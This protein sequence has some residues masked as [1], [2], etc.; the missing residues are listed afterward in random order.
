[1]VL[2]EEALGYL[3][4]GF[5]VIPLISRDKRPEI[6]W[7][8][9][10][11]RK[12]TEDEVRRW[13]SDEK[14]NV[15]IICGKVSG[16][17]VVF[18][19]DNQE[20]MQF[21]ISDIKSVSEKTLVV[22]TGKGFHL[23]YRIKDP[24]Y[25]RLSNLAVDVKGEGGYVVAPPSI[26]PSGV[27]YSV[28]G[29]RKVAEITNEMVSF[30]KEMDEMYPIAKAVLPVW[31]REGEHRHELSLG[32]ASFFRAR[33]KWP[34]EKTERFI[35][36]VMRLK[37]DTEEQQDRMRAIED[38]YKKEYPYNRHLQ[39]ELIEQLVNLLP[40]GSGEIWRWYDKG[41]KDAK[42]WR[43]YMCD[44]TGVYRLYHNER[45]DKDGNPI[46]QEDSETI[47]TQPLTLADAWHA[48]GDEENHVRFTFFLGKIK[49]QGTKTEIFQQ[50][51]ASGL[52]GINWNFIRDTISAC[53]EFYVSTGSVS[54]RQSYEAI[55]IYETEG[56][57]ELALGDKDISALRG[58][59]PWYVLRSFE[60]YA[61]NIQDDLKVFS[62]LPD[63]FDPHLLTLFFGFSAIAPFSYALKGDGD[64]FWP[65]LI[66]KGPKGT[67]KTVLGE[68]FTTYLYG[69]AEGGPADVTSDFRL[70]DFITG[71]T[72]PRLVDE[73]ENAKFEGQKFSIKISTTLKD[74]S[75][76]QLVGTRGNIDR[77]KKLYSARTPLILAGNKIDIEDPALLARTIILNTD[78][79]DK[80]KG[81]QRMQFGA[82]VLRKLHKGFGTRLVNFVLLD[83]PTRQSITEEI[84]KISIPF[85][86]GDPRR[87]DFYSSIYFGLKLWNAFYSSMDLEFP[88][89]YYLD[90]D[91]FTDIIQKIEES[92]VEES[93]ERQSIGEF[94]EWMKKE[95]DVLEEYIKISAEETREPPQRYYELR[96]MIKR[97]VVNN[98]T[99]LYITQAAVTEYCRVN[100]TFQSRSLSEI[101]DV[102]AEYYGM[103]RNTFYDKTARWFEGRTAKAI[104]V[105]LSQA[106]LEDYGK[107]EKE[108]GKPPGSGPPPPA[109]KDLTGL[110]KPNHALV[111]RENENSIGVWSTPNQLT[112]KSDTSH[113]GYNGQNAPWGNNENS[114]Y[115]VRNI[116]NNKDSTKN[117]DLTKDLTRP[118][119]WLGNDD[120][121]LNSINEVKD[122]LLQYELHGRI[123]RDEGMV[124][125]EIAPY[126]EVAHWVSDKIQFMGFYPI[127]S[128]DTTKLTFK[129]KEVPPQ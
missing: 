1:M 33:A 62:L 97:D 36:G 26:H 11:K 10:Q 59:E 69:I 52:T 74:A 49:Y 70:L 43:A 35:E 120:K 114:G 34:K 91:R 77:T 127:E 75:Q 118:N 73:S 104:K 94:I 109:S 78:Q 30:L 54:V 16:D 14:K 112:E 29:S 98:S 51:V 89:A 124:I 85:N 46:I 128:S 83:H 6:N 90:M 111:R 100:T 17:L 55:G 103:D 96:Q 22:R 19:F 105:P 64:F 107:T 115:V 42:S 28:M 129:Y 110:T 119:H 21:V 24:P 27:Q 40:V 9:Y 3:K 50:I 25:F 41:D 8:E 18:D 56:K 63:Y 80:V 31:G 116:V 113:E 60:K 95:A 61:G 5:S 102:L 68:L 81:P 13:F 65:L 92:N 125:I 126:S 122:F 101:A 71:T 37:G 66:F 88:L 87:A 48:E 123:N 32:L 53:V 57:L 58:T 47:F 82:D 4:M 99:W 76:K 108:K 2:V 12:P 79:S 67:G 39:R 86:F 23:Y 20:T 117:K 93:K 7:L 121:F 15:G 38:A 45:M 106:P 84:R 72:F 44:S